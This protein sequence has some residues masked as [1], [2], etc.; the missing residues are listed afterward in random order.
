MNRKPMAAKSRKYCS[1]TPGPF[2]P[3]NAPARS[4]GR[5]TLEPALSNVTSTLSAVLRSAGGL[6][7][8]IQLLFSRDRV[9]WVVTKIL[10]A[11]LVDIGYR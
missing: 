2:D 6:Y 4:H 1:K 11:Q 10:A 8:R 9:V 3:D 7:V 5:L